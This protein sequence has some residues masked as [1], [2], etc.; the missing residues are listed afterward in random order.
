MTLGR[1]LTSSRAEVVVAVG[2]EGEEARNCWTP[3][4]VLCCLVEGVVV[5]SK[6]PG[7]ELK[8]FLA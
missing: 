2:E 8:L 7:K 5:G 3:G 1:G 4:R 6:T